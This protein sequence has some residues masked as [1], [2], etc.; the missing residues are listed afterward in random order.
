VDNKG[1]TGSDI[2]VVGPLEIDYEALHLPGDPE[3]DSPR[4][5]SSR[6]R[7][8]SA[9]ALKLLASGNAETTIDAPCRH[10]AVAP[11]CQ[12]QTLSRPTGPVNDRMRVGLWAAAPRWDWGDQ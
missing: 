8:P 7:H 5:P 3:P 9:E 12:P 10:P 1:W 6:R 2:P 4:V 11:T